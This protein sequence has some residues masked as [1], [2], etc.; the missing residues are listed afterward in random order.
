LGSFV[1]DKKYCKFL[2]MV[3]D[4]WEILSCTGLSA[5]DHANTKFSTGYATTGTG[6]C[7]C[8]RH[9]LIEGE[10]VGDLQKGEQYV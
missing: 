6:V 10:G 3:I 1:K 7:C 5:L 8:A 2:L 4:Q 9:E